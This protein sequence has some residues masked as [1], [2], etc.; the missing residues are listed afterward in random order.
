MLFNHNNEILK[1][2]EIPFNSY[3]EFRSFMNSVA[4]NDMKKIVLV[5]ES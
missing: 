5:K 1:A 2:A 4:G 3:D